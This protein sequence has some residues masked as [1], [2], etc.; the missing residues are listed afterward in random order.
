MGLLKKKKKKK[1]KL[2]IGKMRKRERRSAVDDLE[3][4]ERNRKGVEYYNNS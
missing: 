3:K 4:F 2:G 1:R